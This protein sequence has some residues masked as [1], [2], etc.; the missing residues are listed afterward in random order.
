MAENITDGLVRA[1]TPP[2]TGNRITWDQTV[3]GFG[4]RI[5]KAGARAFVLQYRVGG[6]D[7]RLTIGAY[8]DWSVKAAR[9]EAKRLKR[10]IDLG[11]DPLAAVEEERAA[12]TVAGLMD[13]FKA[14]V[15]PRNRPATATEYASLLDTFA[16]PEIGR[17]KV[18]AV[19]YRDV[20]KLHRKVSE[21][22]PYRANRLVAVLSR[23]FSWAIKEGDRTGA[24]PCKGVERNQEDKRERFLSP[25][26]LAHLSDELNR[27]RDRRTADAIRLLLL[28]G[29]RR[30]EVLSATWE[31][32]DLTAGVWTKPSAH[33]KQKKTHRVPLSA[34]A[35]A[36]LTDMQDQAGDGAVY[37]FPG[38]GDECPHITTIKTA[39]HG[40]TKRATVALWA[41]Q[42]DTEAGRLVADLT[43]NGKLPTWNAVQAEAE[44]RG[45]TL[46]AG[47]T[48]V[49]VHDLRHTYASV[50]ASAGLSLPV[51][52][53]LLGH[54]QTSTTARYAHLIDDTLRA[55]TE[56]AGALIGN[57]GKA[58]ADVVPIRGLKP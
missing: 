7:R 22:A 30:G 40:V 26:E 36:L 8:P 18:E 43:T 11:N 25:L 44:A 3:R 49:R 27:M 20:A 29:A 5:T 53:A 17:M 4:V 57:A 24:N 51:I 19:T 46:P 14:E 45:I 56:R 31:Q 48:D 52:G 23:M 38:D 21:R 35:L 13:R 37:L 50:L 12:P 1:L 33:T 2:E 15:L 39:W 54:T 16:K 34:P 42:S 41:S 9:D 32:F 47:L 58:G 6:R 55:A 28:T 10:D